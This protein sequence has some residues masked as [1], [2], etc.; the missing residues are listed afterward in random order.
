MKRFSLLWLLVIL[1]LA[2]GCKLPAQSKVGKEADI[3]GKITS[4]ERTHGDK[5]IGTILIEGKKEND[6]TFD[7][8][9]VTVSRETK[10]FCAA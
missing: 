4:I 2:A 7:K 3:R 8:A 9:S 1:L 5:A 6:T 10:I